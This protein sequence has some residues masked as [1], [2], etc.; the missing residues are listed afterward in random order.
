MDAEKTKMVGAGFIR[1]KKRPAK[2]AKSGSKV[3][4]GKLLSQHSQVCSLKLRSFFFSYGLA[5]GS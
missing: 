3:P 2:P 4:W 5:F 1:V